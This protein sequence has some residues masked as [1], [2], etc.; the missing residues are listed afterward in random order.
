VRLTTAEAA[1]IVGGTVLGSGDLLLTGAE[2]DSRRVG[3]GDLFVALP[4]ARHDGHEFVGQALAECSAALV[5][6]RSEFQQ[7]PSNRA[8]IRVPDPLPA[9][10]ELARWDRRRRSMEI[11]AVTGSVGKTTVKDFLAQLVSAVHRTGRSEGNR[12]NTLGLPGQLLSAPEDLQLFV[13]ETGMSSPGELDTLGGILQPLRLVLYTRIAPVHTEF[14]P[15]L[16]G[17]VRAKAELLPYLDRGGDLVINGDDTR[18]RIFAVQFPG[19]VLRYGGADGD[20][21]IEIVEDRGLVAAVCELSLPDG[22]ALVELA[23]PGSHQVENLLAAASAAF[24]LGADIQQVAAVAAELKAAPHRGE[25][26]QLGGGVI[27][28]DDSYNASPVA[29]E[30]LLELLRKAPGRRVAVLGEMFELGELTDEA[31]RSVGR[32]A[33]VACDLLLAVGGD[34]AR[35]MATTATATGLSNVRHVVDSEAA[36]ELL[37]DLLET[38]DVVLVKGSRGVGLDRTVGALVREEAA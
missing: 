10:W 17:I 8:L 13:A 26:L 7:P 3:P 22:S 14:F 19:R 31:H 18:H 24:A 5:S 20:C 33:A 32:Q 28:V 6:D 4:G 37:R 15:D 25:V 34:P 12:N 38:G 35:L 1:R 30:R 27:L 2:V 11:A 16:E 23:M 29:V 21:N 9:Y 36:T